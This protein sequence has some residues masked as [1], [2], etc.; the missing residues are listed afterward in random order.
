MSAFARATA[1]RLPGPISQM[2]E[3]SPASPFALI[4]SCVSVSLSRS[5]M[6]APLAP[7]RPPTS[8]P[9]TCISSTTSSRSSSRRARIRLSA[10]W[11]VVSELSSPGSGSILT[12]CPLPLVAS[13]TLRR[14]LHA[15]ES[16][17][18][19]APWVPMSLFTSSSGTATSRLREVSCALMASMRCWTMASALSRSSQ[20]PAGPIFTYFWPS[21]ACSLPL[22]PRF[23]FVLCFTSSVS[24]AA[25]DS[26][27]MALPLLPIRL[28]TH[29]T[30]TRTSR[31]DVFS[32]CEGRSSFVRFAAAL[33]ASFAS[34]TCSSAVWAM[35]L[36]PLFSSARRRDASAPSECGAR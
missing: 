14:A 25:E 6:V 36:A 15:F 33:R 7:M 26:S 4:L 18:M 28:P 16:S 35:V 13:C 19:L 5:R 24:P 29:S 31:N 2:A 8:S 23:P 3:P 30:G 11:S 34:A 9:G 10:F 27:R 32:A 12:T 21:S 20:G 22:P 17:W 1:S